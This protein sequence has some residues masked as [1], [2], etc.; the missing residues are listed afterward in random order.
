MDHSDDRHNFQV[1]AT[2]FYDYEKLKKKI[3]SMEFHN[4]IENYKN[5]AIS[6][7]IEICEKN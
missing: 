5:C 1:V 4:L 6:R 3:E 2:P 7:K